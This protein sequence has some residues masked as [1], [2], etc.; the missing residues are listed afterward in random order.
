[1]TALLIETPQALEG[2]LENAYLEE[3]I[4]LDCEA[5]GFH[6]YTDRLCLIQLSTTKATILIDPLAFDPAPLLRPILED[7]VSQVVMHGADYDVRLLDRD[8]NIRLSNLFDTQV[9]A[10]LLGEEGLGL[11]SLLERH[12]G[13]RLSKKYQKA[14]WARRPLPQE[15][16]DYAAGDT[17]HLHELADLLGDRLEKARRTSWAKEEFRALESIRW[18]EQEPEDP[19]LRIREAKELSLRQ[20]FALRKALAWR[21][22]VA[23]ERDRATFRVAP[24]GALVDV[25]RNLPGSMEEL[26]EIRGLSRAL[27]RDSGQDLLAEIQEVVRAPETELT[28]YPSRSRNG[29]RNGGRARLAPDEEERANKLKEARNRRARELGIDRG[30]L[31]PNAV[32]ADV[33][34]KNPV[35]PDAL[36]QVP[37]MKRWQVEA[38]GDAL[39]KALPGS[40]KR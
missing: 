35:S 22:G 25:A 28:P 2:A 12:L 31:L 37:G 3:R 32:V 4:A 21:D 8:L 39:L 26:E 36:A 13:V 5:A 24:D 40:Q 7:P 20:L 11:S 18:E 33:A 15:Y 10:S 38:V 34:R 14:D 9:A 29:S 6:R 17:Q 19:V 27:L 16:Q 23:K 30:T 1:M